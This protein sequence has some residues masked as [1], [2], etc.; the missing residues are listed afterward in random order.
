MTGSIHIRKATPADLPSLVALLRELF[1]LEAEFTP[2]DDAQRRGLEM[3]LGDPDHGEIL[4]AERDR[5]PLAMVTLLYTVSTALGARV[6]LLEDMV[7][8]AEARGDGTGGTLLDA[9][10]ERCRHNGCARVTLLTDADNEGAQAFYRRHGFAR[11]GMHAYRLLI[12]Q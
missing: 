12:E 10:I 3:V 4:V 9:A 8:K 6:A 1:S 11:S 2:D 5:Q 7:V